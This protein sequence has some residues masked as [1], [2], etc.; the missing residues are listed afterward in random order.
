MTLP[1]PHGYPILIQ[2]R[3]PVPGPSPD[4]VVWQDHDYADAEKAGR[5]L[6]WGDN[7]KWYRAVDAVTREPIASSEPEERILKL[8]LANWSRDDVDIL[9]ILIRRNS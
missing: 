2:I 6:G 3:V 8:N 7:A 1:N 5:F 4:S 9:D